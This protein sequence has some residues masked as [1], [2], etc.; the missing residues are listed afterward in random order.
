MWVLEHLKL[1]GSNYIFIGQCC[2]RKWN[3][4]EYSFYLMK[5]GKD[6]GK[7]PNIDTSDVKD[8]IWQWKTSERLYL[9]NES[10]SL[11]DALLWVYFFYVA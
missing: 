7:A 9:M 2:S 5:I 8:Y 3:S 10:F 11:C 6:G 1:C 4:H